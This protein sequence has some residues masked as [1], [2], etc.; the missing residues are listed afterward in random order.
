[1]TDRESRERLV[2]LLEKTDK[3]W[4]NINRQKADLKELVGGN[5]E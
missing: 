3:E 1:M 5:D 2:E 4:D